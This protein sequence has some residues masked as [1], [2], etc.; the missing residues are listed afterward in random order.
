MSKTR[1]ILL[2]SFGAYL[3]IFVLLIVIYGFTQHKNDAF[4]I[5][6]EFKLV[7]WVH[8]GVF[9]INRAVLYLILGRWSTSPSACRRA[10]TGCRPRS[11]R[12]SR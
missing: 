12:C 8:L 9:S 4:Q 5:Q 6:N 1:K 11:R 3:G 7:N 10:P 2:A